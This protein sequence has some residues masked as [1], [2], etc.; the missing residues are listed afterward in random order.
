MVGHLGRSIPS[1]T[2][3]CPFPRNDAALR[4]LLIP[5]GHPRLPNA[6]RVTD[7]IICGNEAFHTINLAESGVVHGTSLPIAAVLTACMTR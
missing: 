2:G 6:R 5:I 3:S 4:G 1:V 7:K